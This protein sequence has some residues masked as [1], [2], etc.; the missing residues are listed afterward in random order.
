MVGLALHR[1]VFALNDTLSQTRVSPANDVVGS[2][3]CMG[4]A[5]TDRLQMLLSENAPHRAL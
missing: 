5:R 2:L 1:G 4:Q 3:R